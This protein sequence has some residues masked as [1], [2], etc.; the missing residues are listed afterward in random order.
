MSGYIY[1]TLHPD[2]ADGLGKVLPPASDLLPLRLILLLVV[3]PSV[4]KRGDGLGRRLFP[5]L[6]DLAEEPV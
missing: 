4:R 2:H 6:L 1:H 3:R 5:K